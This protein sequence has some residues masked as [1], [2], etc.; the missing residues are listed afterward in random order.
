MITALG[1]PYEHLSDVL[2]LAMVE[3]KAYELL[4][5]RKEAGFDVDSVDVLVGHKLY[6]SLLSECLDRPLGLLIKKDHHPSPL[7]CFRYNHVVVCLWD[8]IPQDACSMVFLPDVHT[9]GADFPNL[10]FIW[11]NC[12]P[13]QAMDFQI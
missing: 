10:H 13:I 11:L 4:R 5:A 6:Q 9:H 1:H 3:K 8:S 2:T 7:K 12:K